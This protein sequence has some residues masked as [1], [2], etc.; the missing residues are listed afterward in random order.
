MVSRALR[1]VKGRWIRVERRAGIEL[2]YEAIVMDGLTELVLICWRFG[3]QDLSIGES[4]RKVENRRI[5]KNGSRAQIELV[6]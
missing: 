4:G 3:I 2:R 6:E 5:S 1:V